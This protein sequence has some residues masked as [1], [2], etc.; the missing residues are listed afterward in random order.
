M[1]LPDA[2]ILV[3]GLNCITKKILENNKELNFRISLAKTAKTTLMVESIPREETVHRL[4]EHLVGEVE[5]VVHL[6]LNKKDE[7]KTML[8]RINV[9]YPGGKGPGKGREEN[10]NPKK[11]DACRFFPTE[12][13]CKKGKMRTWRHTLD[14]Q[15]RC[16]TCGAKEHLANICP[17]QD[18]KAE[19]PLKKEK[20]KKEKECPRFR[21]NKKDE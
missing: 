14:D 9:D 11:D 18:G 5:Q 2:T 10:S 19:G 1:A 20:E 15:R 6:D 12:G 8:K 3:R 7:P 4:A 17:R 16:W 21:R 13:G